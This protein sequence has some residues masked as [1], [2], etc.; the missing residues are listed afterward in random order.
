MLK[1]VTCECGW[2]A[3]GTEDELVPMIQQHGRDVHGMEVTREQAVA[4]IVP[5]E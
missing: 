5:A 4:Q 1:Q 3:K 2:S